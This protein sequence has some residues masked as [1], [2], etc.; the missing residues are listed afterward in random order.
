MYLITSLQ[1]L[2]VA[3]VDIMITGALANTTLSDSDALII[4]VATV[5]ISALLVHIIIT[6]TKRK[7]RQPPSETVP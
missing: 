5:V 1:L 6:D 4:G 2:M 3:V 7:L